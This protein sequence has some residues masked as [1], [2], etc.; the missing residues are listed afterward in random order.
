MTRSHIQVTPSRESHVMHITYWVCAARETPIFNPKFPLRSISF[1]SRASPFLVEMQIL[2]CCRSGDH[3]FQIFFPFKPVHHRPRPARLPARRVHPSTVSQYLVPET[4]L[5]PT[6]SVPECPILV[7]GTPIFT[8]EPFRRPPPP[9]FA[10]C[11]GTY[12]PKCRV[13]AP[14]PPSPV[15]RMFR[16]I[17]LAVAISW[18]LRGF[19]WQIF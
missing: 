1:R 6:M 17:E 19:S 13:S 16:E 12:L 2:N 14:P 7:P 11:R 18:P 5:I 9:H 15:L 4:P 3:R 8:P 10:L